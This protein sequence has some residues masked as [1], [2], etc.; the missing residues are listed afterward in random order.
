MNR[1]A[2]VAA[3]ALTGCTQ[4]VGTKQGGSVTLYRNSALDHSLRV[5]WA[6]FDVSDGVDYNLGNCQMAA[7]LLNANMTASAV[8]LEQQRDA[9]IG[10]W[11]EVGKYK[12]DGTVPQSFREEYPT[13]SDA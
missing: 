1:L 4:I 5:H 6:T 10:F 8:K 3:L 9:E 2:I 12:H 7:R 13:D 11:C